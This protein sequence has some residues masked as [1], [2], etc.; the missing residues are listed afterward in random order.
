M[1]CVRRLDAGFDALAR[2]TD[3]ELGALRQ[4]VEAVIRGVDHLS[5]L[6]LE[7]RVADWSSHLAP[8][9][10]DLA[11]QLPPHQGCD[12]PVL[13]GAYE[14]T[15]LALHQRFEW[16]DGDCSTV[17]DRF[18]DA[19]RAAAEPPSA[20]RRRRWRNGSRRFSGYPVQTARR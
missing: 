18:L 7:R 10:W 5:A 11:S 19:L 15:R 8:V 9:L 4:R 1:A 6:A 3:A 20:R 2:L 13:A 14:D 12:D 17:I 16:N